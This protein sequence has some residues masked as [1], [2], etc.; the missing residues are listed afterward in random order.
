MSGVGQILY[1]DEFDDCLGTR[2]ERRRHAGK[3]LRRQ[4]I[5]DLLG[6]LTAGAEQ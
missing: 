3:L 4:A 6:S 1:P 2:I 5:L